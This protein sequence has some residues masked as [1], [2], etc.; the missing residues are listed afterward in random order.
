MPWVRIDEHA[1]SHPKI[2]G[3]SDGSFR[4]WV[5]A[6]AHCQNVLTDGLVKTIALRG[7]TAYTARRRAELIE[8]GLWRDADNGIVVHDYLQW[9]DSRAQVLKAREAEKNRK[10]R[11][12]DGVRGT[13]SGRDAGQ[14][15]GRTPTSPV[16]ACVVP[17]PPVAEEREG[18]V[19]ETNSQRAG[20]FA[21][22]YADAHERTLGVGYIGP[23]RDYEHA[24]R[25]CEKFTDTELHDAAM[26]WFGQDDDF[27]VSG[28]RTIAKFA[29]RASDCVL[30]ARKVASRFSA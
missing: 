6:L 11:W 20:R 27:A 29:S 26:V 2:A 12:R 7:M 8:A 30:T 13:D 14:D 25:L 24:L 21:Q 17:T 18:G 10:R 28:T 9:N 23:Y 22:W 19:G 1:M 3:L 4:L 5:Q 16:R 15:G